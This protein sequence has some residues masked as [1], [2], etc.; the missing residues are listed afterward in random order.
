[1]PPP[2]PRSV[3]TLAR[4]QVAASGEALEPRLVYADVLTERGDPRGLFIT[5][6]C[7][8][9][10]AAAS[11]LLEKY[12]FHFMHPLP[13][14]AEV[15]FRDGFIDTWTTT[16][17]EFRSWGRRL[18]RN[19]PLRRLV[20]SNQRACDVKYVVE[21]VGFEQVRVLE[22]INPWLGALRWLASLESLPGLRT[23]GVLGSWQADERE[24]LL[25]SKLRQ[26]LETLE[27]TNVI[28]R[29]R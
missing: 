8:G 25:D 6:Q 13:P 1:M 4:E 11:A 3:V 19:N 29:V 18:L 26:G 14:T 20:L 24:A 5:A 9:N 27:F 12:R 22:L 7:T 17:S 28:P 23:L 21:S 2:R 16:A 15:V 10:H